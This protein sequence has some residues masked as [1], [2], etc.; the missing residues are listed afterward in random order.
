MN[1]AQFYYGNPNNSGSWE[2]AASIFAAHNS[3]NSERTSS[4]PLV[5]YWK[6]RENGKVSESGK[7][8]LDQCELTL[9]DE[10]TFCF[11]YPVPVNKD[12]GG[13]GKASMTDLM[14]TSSSHAIAIEAKWTEGK[15]ETIEHWC[16]S[17]NRSKVLKGWF[18]Y[19]NDYI[20]SDVLKI[21]EFCRYGDIPYQMVHRIAS[22]CKTAMEKSGRK[23]VV[24]YQLFYDGE[25]YWSEDV[26]TRKNMEDLAGELTQQYEL[27]FSN[28]LPETI[29][30]R[31]VLIETRIRDIMK[32][33][34]EI[35]AKRSREDAA[36]YNDL[37][38]LMQERDIYE[39][40][41]VAVS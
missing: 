26:V 9:D 2:Q 36:A 7:K 1:K 30:F 17:E 18:K 28:N 13:K 25:P 41:G 5:Q 29:S 21:D 38:I 3:V 15:P 33:D 40:T 4:L 19:I 39:F 20:G 12:E 22:A 16:T 37:F 31:S 11:E 14:I 32:G 6:P 34:I 23:A 35:V 24:I 10:A 8:L 27:L